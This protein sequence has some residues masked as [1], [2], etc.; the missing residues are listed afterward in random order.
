M[1]YILSNVHLGWTYLKVRV[2]EMC[3]LTIVTCNNNWPQEINL[4]LLNFP[5]YGS[6]LNRFTAMSNIFSI[7]Y[8]YM[9]LYGCITIRFVQFTIS[10][11]I[12]LCSV[13]VV[14]QDECK[15][16]K[17]VFNY[18]HRYI[19]QIICAFKIQAKMIYPHA[20]TDI[21]SKKGS[22]LYKLMKLLFNAC[23]LKIYNNFED[24]SPCNTRRESY[25]SYCQR[26]SVFW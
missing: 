1:P 12:A 16:H 13:K 20:N 18:I 25:W 3:H 11:Y 22:L 26:P 2:S 17:H 23:L 6:L 8:S 10:Y 14:F 4:N 9:V 24:N 5:S 19:S 15:V 7:M 21:D